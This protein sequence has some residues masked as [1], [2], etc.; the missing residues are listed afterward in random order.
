MYLHAPRLHVLQ[1]LGGSLR[2]ELPVEI[3]LG[4]KRCLGSEHLSG[5][6]EQ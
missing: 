5:S 6:V 3:G 4:K 2:V 1:D